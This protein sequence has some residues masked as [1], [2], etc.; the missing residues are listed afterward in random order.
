M[1]QQ[2]WKVIAR[3]LQPRNFH[4]GTCMCGRDP[5]IVLMFLPNILCCVLKFLTYY[6]QKYA[7]E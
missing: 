2:P 3:L 4:M 6:A 7:Q 5:F 1:L